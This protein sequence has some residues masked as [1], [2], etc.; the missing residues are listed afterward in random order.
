LRDVEALDA[1]TTRRLLGEPGADTPSDE[2]P[3]EGIE[4]PRD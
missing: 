4:A 3:L 2:D 1:D